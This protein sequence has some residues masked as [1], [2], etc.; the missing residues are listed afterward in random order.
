MISLFATIELLSGNKHSVSSVYAPH[1]Y[2]N[3]ISR[4][5]D[6]VQNTKKVAKN[7]FIIGSTR[8]GD[9]ATIESSADYFISQSLSDE[10][11]LFYFGDDQVITIKAGET[12][13]LTIV[14]D[15][16]KNGH[17]I[18][19]VVDGKEY[20]DDDTIFTI[21][22]LEPK[23]KHTIKILDWNE[24]FRPLVVTGIYVGVK[25]EID[26]HNLR[27]IYW[28]LSQRGDLK[29][30]SYGIISNVGEIEFNDND[31]EVLDYIEQLVTEQGH[32]CKLYLYNSLSKTTCNIA[33]A[34]TSEWDY[35]SSNRLVSVQLK[36]DLEEWQNIQV[37]AI[38]YNPNDIVEHNAL[39]IYA[40]LLNYVP[41]KFDMIT[42]SELEILDYE[43]FN[44]LANTK[45]PH[46]LLKSGTLWEQWQKL[47][48]LCGLYIYKNNEG[49][50]IC[51]Y[52]F[53]G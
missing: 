52:T 15:T 2:K 4:N 16:T 24:P 3:N 18:R 49:K 25:I 37:P 44:I 5:I 30:P 53:G 43:T 36:D 7:P 47:C 12:T 50:T 17:P 45:I 33:K 8:L 38:N 6:V 34:K 21:T 32:D 46:Y 41:S 11:G 13:N 14:F 29:L 23:S 31:G 1:I 51:S 20:V 26:N 39:D 19:I 9:G 22:D 35:K 27:S 48:E 42:S 10:K 40:Y 28:D